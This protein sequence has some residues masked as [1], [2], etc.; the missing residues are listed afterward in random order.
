MTVSFR[1]RGSGVRRAGLR[2]RARLPGPGSRGRRPRRDR[3]PRW[4]SPQS[5]RKAAAGRRASA[6]TTIAPGKPMAV[7][8][9]LQ[10]RLDALDQRRG[11]ADQSAAGWPRSRGPGPP[12]RPGT[13]ASG[14]WSRAASAI[15]RPQARASSAEPCA[16]LVG[17]GR[18]GSTNA[19]VRAPGR[20]VLR[21]MAAC[22]PRRWATAGARPRRR[23]RRV[24]ASTS[25]GVKCF[26]TR[27][28]ARSMPP[29]SSNTVSKVKRAGGHV[30]HSVIP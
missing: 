22:A 12:G 16:V 18:P 11:D 27:T 17:H 14:N 21:A 26:F 19:P 3:R 2:R 24:A 28:A 9:L 15:A 1:C 5:R 6:R 8:G 20:C 23:P 13:G 30:G 10:G 4:P 25:S 29:S 7:G